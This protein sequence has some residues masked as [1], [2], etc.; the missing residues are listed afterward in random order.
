MTIGHLVINPGDEE[1]DLTQIKV[2]GLGLGRTGTTSLIM[3]VMI[4]L[5]YIV[6]VVKRILAKP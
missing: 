3:A 2:V 5:I 6:L 1:E 4:P